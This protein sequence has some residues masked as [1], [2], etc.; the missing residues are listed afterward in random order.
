MA[1][2]QNQLGLKVAQDYLAALERAGI[3][4]QQ[5]FLYGSRVKNLAREDSDFD[6]AIVS[7]ALTDSAFENRL[8]LRAVRRPINLLIDPVGFKPSRFEAWHPFVQEIL[9]TGIKIA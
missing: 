7:D 8:I 5:A 3:K 4:V 9:A 1:Q 2:T 6:I